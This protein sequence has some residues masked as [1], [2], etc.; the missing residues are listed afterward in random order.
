MRVQ[1]AQ[2]L[3]TGCVLRVVYLEMITIIIII[4]PEL[5]LRF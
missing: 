3:L 5:L 4:N 2:P 1:D